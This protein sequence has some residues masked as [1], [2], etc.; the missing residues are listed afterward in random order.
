MAELPGE[1]TNDASDTQSITGKQPENEP[2]S[3]TGSQARCKTRAGESSSKTG[4]AYVEE[5]SYRSS[6]AGAL[7]AV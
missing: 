5:G 7:Q 4:A 2:A 3:E 1:S 6:G